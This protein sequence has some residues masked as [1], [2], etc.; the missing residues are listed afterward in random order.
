MRTLTLS[1]AVLL[2][3]GC[4][5][6]LATALGVV[7]PG[8]NVTTEL[9][10]LYCGT[11]SRW[12]AALAAAK[13]EYQERRAQLDVRPGMAACE[14][15]ARIGLPHERTT[16]AVR[17][18]PNAEHW[19]YMVTPAGRRHSEPKLVVLVQENRATTSLRVD[20]VV[21]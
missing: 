7:V 18:L 9:G 2:L 1:L 3:G 11:P 14:V 19:T 6:Q 5:H 21:W 10:A 12:D 17:D 16:V 20:S 15:L 8:R 4:A 13:A